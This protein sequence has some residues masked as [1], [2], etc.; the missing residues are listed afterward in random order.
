MNKFGALITPTKRR[1]ERLKFVYLI[2]KKKK[3]T[4]KTVGHS[5]HASADR[6]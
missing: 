1:H 4:K 3:Q 6:S 5:L 2:L